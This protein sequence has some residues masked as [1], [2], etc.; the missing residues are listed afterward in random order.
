MRQVCCVYTTKPRNNQ[1]QY[2]GSDSPCWR[3]YDK[4]NYYFS[5]N[6]N[7]LSLYMTNKE[8][9]CQTRHQE[10]TLDY[11]KKTGRCSRLGP[12]LR[13]IRR[14]VLGMRLWL[15]QWAP[16]ACCHELVGSSRVLVALRVAQGFWWQN[17][18]KKLVDWKKMYS[19]DQNKRRL[20]QNVKEIFGK[21]ESVSVS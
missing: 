17:S 20:L 12:S 10:Q 21:F 1:I 8:G 16:R 6:S 2:G 11:Q 7:P 9:N 18:K 14:E 5:S 3:G 19:S 13:A 4:R 15:L